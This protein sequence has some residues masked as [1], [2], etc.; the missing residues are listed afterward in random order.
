MIEGHYV[1]SVFM[2]GLKRVWKE[3]RLGCE[4]G[5]FWIE[6][7]EGRVEVR[8]TD[9]LLDWME[10]YGRVKM[11]AGRRIKWVIRCELI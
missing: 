4:G 3:L 9:S 8:S 7:Y 10:M 1:E 6:V 5:V 11:M 2:G